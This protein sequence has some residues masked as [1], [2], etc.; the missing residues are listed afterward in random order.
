MCLYE[1]QRTQDL[2]EKSGCWKLEEALDRT[3]WGTGFGKDCG[4]DVKERAE[5]MNRM[6]FACL[7]LV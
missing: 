4:P 7:K 1:G 3:V 6:K 2:K 5:W